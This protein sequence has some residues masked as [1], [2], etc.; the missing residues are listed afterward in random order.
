MQ[1]KITE[2]QSNTE[3]LEEVR[4]LND[5]FTNLE[6]QLLVTKNVNSLLQE[7][8]I[9]FER[10]CWANA[11]YSKREC[12]EVAG[13]PKSVKQNE[14]EDKVLRIFKKFSSDIPSDN[15]EACHRVG[16]H[17]NVIIK[18]SKRKDCQQIFSVKKDLSKLDMKEVDLP[19]GTQI[20]VNQSLCP[21]YKSLWSKSKK[22]RSLGKIHSFFISNSTIKIKLQENS[23]PE[24]I[25]HSSEF[26]K[27]FP[28]VDLSQSN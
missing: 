9:D 18:F 25:T 22:L 13:I 2:M 21:Y 5:K 17:N 1:S 3:I 20:F 7:R 8:V 27:F 10:K 12:L 16:R 15:I 11:Q 19:E 24:S 4:K 23:N 28:D 6:S 14:L 26:D